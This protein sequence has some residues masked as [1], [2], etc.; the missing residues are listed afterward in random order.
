[1]VEVTET[2]LGRKHKSHRHVV[3]LLE[4][5]E[6][7]EL[8]KQFAAAIPENEMSVCICF[9][10]PFSLILLL[11]SGLPSRGSGDLPS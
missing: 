8:A 2:R 10:F 6:L 7:A 9:F 4:E 11:V 5:E 1:V 3:P